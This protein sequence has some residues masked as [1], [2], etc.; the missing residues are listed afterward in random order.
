MN[1]PTE[2]LEQTLSFAR[3]SG[4]RLGEAKTLC[5][6]GSI[7]LMNGDTRGAMELFEQSI[8]LAREVGDLSIEGHALWGMCMV[9]MAAEID[10]PQIRDLQQIA[11]G[12]FEKLGDPT[13]DLV[14][15]ILAKQQSRTR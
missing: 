9:W 4:D 12:I 7:Q 3:K 13:A 6:M 2:I 1:Q 15:E 10:T 11:L 8:Q 5:S 14:R